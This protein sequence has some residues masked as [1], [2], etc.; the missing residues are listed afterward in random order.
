[1]A[2]RNPNR[3][4]LRPPTAPAVKIP[5]RFRPS[6]AQ[7]QK[8]HPISTLP[9][10]IEYEF[11]YEKSHHEEQKLSLEVTP[12]HISNHYNNP[13]HS[14]IQIRVIDHIYYLHRVVLSQM[15][16]FTGL[17]NSGMSETKTG[18]ID[19]KDNDPVCLERMFL[20]AYDRSVKFDTFE[21]VI[22]LLD[23]A[24]YFQFPRL[25]NAIWTLIDQSRD[26]NVSTR[27]LSLMKNAQY[28]RPYTVTS[29]D[30]H[31][32][33]LSQISVESIKSLPLY[34]RQKWFT[35]FKWFLAHPNEI[36]S[37][38]LFND[39]PL[40][41]ITWEDTQMLATYKDDPSLSSLVIT[42]LSTFIG[43]LTSWTMHRETETSRGRIP[44]I[45]HRPLSPTSPQI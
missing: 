22:D 5:H 15:E 14:D 21:E 28:N 42:I 13:Q 3:V 10:P 38:T 44:N 31:E 30:L 29:R 33:V 41:G 20:F 40:E 4:H 9:D 18:I 7:L 45:H 35:L 2:K 11:P 32:E 26:E 19:L 6:L 17:L 36:D 16:F 23:V 34:G 27:A 43:R 8:R 24:Y 1:M 39:V 37:A 12:T 25:Q